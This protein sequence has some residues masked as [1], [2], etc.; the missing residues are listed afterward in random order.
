MIR[1]IYPPGFGVR[2]SPAAF[3]CAYEPNCGL[4]WENFHTICRVVGL[5]LSQM[6]TKF[7]A[8]TPAI[9]FE[10]SSLHHVLTG[11]TLMA[12]ELSE[13]HIRSIPR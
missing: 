5:Q 7:L 2:L 1:L 10:T 4:V 6:G 3:R 12:N 11:F 9:V 8:W 13:I